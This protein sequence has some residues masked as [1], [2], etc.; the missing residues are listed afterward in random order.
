MEPPLRISTP[1][2]TT[3]T[4]T[5]TQHTLPLLASAQATKGHVRVPGFLWISMVVHDNTGSHCKL[6]VW[7][8]RYSLAAS[9]IMV[10]LRPGPS[11]A[12]AEWY[13][14]LSLAFQSLTI[15]FS[16]KGRWNSVESMS[17]P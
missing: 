11:S 12:P 14:L 7:L 6:Q 17:S 8:D 1:A 16:L 13:H 15:L 2:G 9:Y 4:S 3:S 10:Q 5:E